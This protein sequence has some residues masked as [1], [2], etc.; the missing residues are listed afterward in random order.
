[1]G[2]ED[3]DKVLVTLSEGSVFGEISLLAINGLNR[4]TADVRLVKAIYINK[5]VSIVH[6]R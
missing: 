5:I 3:N 4:R 6:C 1:M 2:G